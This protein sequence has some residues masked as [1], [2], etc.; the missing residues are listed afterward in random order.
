MG[1]SKEVLGPQ[2][3]AEEPSHVKLLAAI[4]GARVALEEKIETVAVGLNLL[5]TD[6]H[7]VSDNIKVAEG[8]I[9]DLQTERRKPRIVEGIGITMDM[10]LKGHLMNL[11]YT[12]G[13]ECFSQTMIG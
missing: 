3:T 2:A 9:V 13:E 11:Y 7:K 4:Q 12:K 6:L 8:S 10:D 1:G 5:R